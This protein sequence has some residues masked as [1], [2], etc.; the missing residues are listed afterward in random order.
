LKAIELEKKA[1]TKFQDILN[2][3]FQSMIDKDKD[4]ADYRDTFDTAA[5]AL[6]ANFSLKLMVSLVFDKLDIPDDE[7]EKALEDLA[8]T[9]KKNLIKEYQSSGLL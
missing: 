6:A 5:L 1:N 7:I 3:I 9:T 4:I 8:A 2:E